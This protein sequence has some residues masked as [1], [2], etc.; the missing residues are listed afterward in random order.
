MVVVGLLVDPNSMNNAPNVANNEEA[1]KQLQYSKNKG[2][3]VEVFANACRD[4]G[5]NSTGEWNTVKTQ[6]QAF[7]GHYW[8]TYSKRTANSNP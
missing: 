5:S 3:A 1:E 7:R 4:A 6:T 2:Q 8:H